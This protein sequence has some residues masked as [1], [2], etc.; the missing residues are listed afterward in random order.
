M[1]TGW[2]GSAIATILFL[3]TGLYSVFIFRMY[4]DE[5]GAMNM[6][7]PIERTSIV[8]RSA[9]LIILPASLIL[10]LIPLLG[11]MLTALRRPGDITASN[12]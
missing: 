2:D 3:I 5:Q 4:R 9:Y 7:T 10:W 1:A 12:L 6:A 8:T 11:V